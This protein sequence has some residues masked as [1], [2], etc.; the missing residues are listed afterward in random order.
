MAPANE[1]I[2]EFSVRQVLDMLAP[3]NFAASNPEVLQKAFQ[4]GG[5]NFLFGWQNWCS[6]L[7]RL[8]AMARRAI[9]RALRAAADGRYRRGRPELAG[10]AWG[11]CAS[12]AGSGAWSSR[13]NAL[14][15][16]LQ[17]GQLSVSLFRRAQETL[18]ILG[19]E[20]F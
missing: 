14:F 16:R 12:I 11:L 7:M 9:R 4:S 13:A 20:K 10:R 18:F 3:S 15:P 6:D 1:A 17:R 8:D 19:R 5:E 2:V